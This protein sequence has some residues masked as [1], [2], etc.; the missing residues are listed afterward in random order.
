MISRMHI[1]PTFALLSSHTV[2]V[3][4]LRCARA[5]ALRRVDRACG[6]ARASRAH[7]RPARRRAG[8]RSNADADGCGAARQP[9]GRREHRD[10]QSELLR[11]DAEELRG[12]VDESRSERVRAAQRL[13]DARHG[14]GARQRAVQSDSL[15]RTCSTSR[16][17][18]SPPASARRAMHTSRRSSTRMREPDFNQSELVAD[19]ANGGLRHARRRRR[20]AR[21]RRARPPKRSSSP[22]RTARCSASRSMNH[23]CMDM[24]QVHDTSIAPDRIRQDV[25]RSPGGDS[26]VFMNN[27]IGCHAGMDPMAQA[28]AYYDFDET[29]RRMVYDATAVHSKYF[30]NDTT[31]PDGFVTPN[32]SWHNHWRQGQN[33]LIGWNSGAAG[34]RQ[35]REVARRGARRLASVRAVP[36]Q[37]GVQRRVPARSRSIETIAIRSTR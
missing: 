25:S 28:F 10:E 11:G 37:E 36:G 26:R 29:S 9:D 3:A 34:P 17:G 18:V 6:T 14:H 5:T 16:P 23:M 19:D 12:A 20:P 30:N 27:C 35:R 15:R 7:S 13:H 33:A 24:E 21:S 22:A 32:D 4:H 8:R 31:F 1:T 2:A